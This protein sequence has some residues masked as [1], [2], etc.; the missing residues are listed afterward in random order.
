MQSRWPIPLRHAL[1]DALLLGVTLGLWRW[2]ASLRA[3]SASLLTVGVALL[4]GAMTALCGYLAHEWGHLAGAWAG[5]SRVHLPARASDVFLFR[6]DSDRNTRAQFLIMSLGGFLASGLA[7][8]ILLW[9]LPLGTLAARVAMGLVVAGVVATVILEFPPA[10][11]VAR[12]EAIP[13][14]AAYRSGAGDA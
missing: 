5:G 6:F 12:G 10:W 13:T 14:G 1:R 2:D 3:Q 11:R 7:I 4:A 9:V 8:A